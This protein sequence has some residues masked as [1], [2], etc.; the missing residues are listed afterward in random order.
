M[1]E[2]TKNTKVEDI[3]TNEQLLAEARTRRAGGNEEVIL[4]A[5]ILSVFR[6][7]RKH[8][9]IECR[10]ALEIRI[11]Q[12][13]N[14]YK[15]RIL[16]SRISVAAGLLLLIGL[17]ALINHYRPSEL[18]AFAENNPAV[19]GEADTRLVISGDEVK[20]DSEES[21]IDYSV[22][23]NAIKI[24]ASEQVTQA[25]DDR[26]PVINAVIVPYGKRTRVTLSDQ[27]VV[28]LNSGSRLVFPAK[29]GKQKR[30]VYLEGEAIFEV[31]HDST[32]PFHVLTESL[33]VKVLGTVFNISAYRD[34]SLTS[35]VLVMGSVELSYPGK[36]L[37]GNSGCRMTPGMLVRYDPGTG[38]IQSSEVDTRLYTSWRDGYLIFHKQPLI[39]I[40]KK[41]SRYYNVEIR[42]EDPLLGNETFSGSLDL[43]T[44]APDL[45]QV[46]TEIIHARVE[47]VD[48]QIIIKRI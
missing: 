8:L 47:D 17:P 45:L 21:K 33:S 38:N 22:G 18:L 41:I 42:L 40:L 16:I 2:K 26:K 48:N 39:N 15:R 46:V 19:S 11:V 24:D 31:A 14:T 20:I 13:I 9:G 3:L 44:S 34:D 37:F 27:S 10:K 25:V 36:A 28:W 43:K 12:S 30:E 4:A 29:F 1:H 23:G 35:T 5:K 7:C 32:H 6:G